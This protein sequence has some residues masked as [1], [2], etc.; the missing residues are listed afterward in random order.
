MALGIRKPISAAT[1]AN[2]I[3]VHIAYSPGFRLRLEC[4]WLQLLRLLADC[5]YGGRGRAPPRISRASSL[6]RSREVA[7]S[8]SV[9]SRQISARVRVSRGGRAP[10][11]IPLDSVIFI[12]PTV[13][14]NWGASSQP[15]RSGWKVKIELVGE[16]I[17]HGATYLFR[18]VASISSAQN[19]KGHIIDKAVQADV[20]YRR[21]WLLSSISP[22]SAIQGTGSLRLRRLIGY[23]FQLVA[24]LSKSERIKGEHVGED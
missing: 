1:G 13:K 17:R 12:P 24:I 2:E 18:G 16:S 6:V 7:A 23:N 21:E 19:S 20:V 10:D 15:R 5:L 3:G 22:R 4:R 8:C 11:I 9:H 14:K